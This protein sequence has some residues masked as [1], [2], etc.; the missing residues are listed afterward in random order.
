MHDGLIYL[1]CKYTVYCKLVT[2]AGA[3]NN[4]LLTEIQ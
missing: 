4:H 1:Y 3:A 2:T